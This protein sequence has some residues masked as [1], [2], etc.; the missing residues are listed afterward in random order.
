MSLHCQ[1]LKTM[2]PHVFSEGY[3]DELP[4]C[5]S[6][7]LGVR[8]LRD[9]N[10]G[11]LGEPQARHP[12]PQTLALKYSH[13]LPRLRSFQCSNPRRWQEEAAFLRRRVQE[14]EYGGRGAESYELLEG[15]LAGLLL[16]VAT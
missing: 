11:F 9:Q 8:M 7:I 12:R 13:P 14:T 5:R 16:H 4:G 6:G 2:V 10:H 1:A 15:F 3:E